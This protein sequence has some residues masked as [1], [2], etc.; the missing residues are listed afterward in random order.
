MAF[1][2][3]KMQPQGRLIRSLVPF[4]FDRKSATRFDTLES[5]ITDIWSRFE[6]VLLMHTVIF[7]RADTD[8]PRGL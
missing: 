6:P 1:G 7:A 5:V 2:G 4:L 3:R 8:M